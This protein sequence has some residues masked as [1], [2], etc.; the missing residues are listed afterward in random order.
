MKKT[1][2]I[3][4]AIGCI[5]VATTRVNAQAIPRVLAPDPAALLAELQLHEWPPMMHWDLREFPGCDVPWA[6]NPNPV[7]DLDGNGADNTAADRAAARAAFAASFA[8]WEAVAPS[9]IGFVESGTPALGGPGMDGYNTIGFG[10]GA[11]DDVQVVAPGN[12]V[13]AGGVVVGPGPNGVLESQ[14]GGDDIVAGTDIVDGGNLVAESFANTY[15]S[16]V[17]AL[18]FTVLFFDMPTGRIIESDITFDP[19]LAWVVNPAT[20]ACSPP[21]AVA[22]FN[23][24]GTAVHEI[25]HFI[26]IAHPINPNPGAADAADG[27]TPT[28]HPTLCPAFGGNNF[29]Q[30]LENADRDPCNFLYTP[31]LGDAPDPWMGVFNQY[32]TLV[33]LVGQGRVLNELQLDARAEGAEHIFGIK[34]VQGARNWTYEWLARFNGPGVTPECE[35]NI[36]D[37]DPLDDGVTWYPNPP[38]WGRLLTVTAWIKY[39]SDAQGNAHNYPAR[40]LF[41]NAWID[42]NQNC[43]WEEW[44][45]SVGQAPPPPLGPNTI[46]TTTA[47][48]SVFLPPF[49]DPT[50][51]VWLRARVD[52]GE[53]VG[54]INNIDGTLNAERGAAQFGEVEDYPM[55]CRTKYEQQWTQNVLPYPTTGTSL[56]FVGAPDPA[57]QFYSAIVDDNDCPIETAPLPIVSYVPSLDETITEYPVPTTVPPGGRKHSGKCKPN[58]PPGQPP[59][60]LL[61]SHWVTDQ[62]PAQTPAH[63]V[64]PELRIPSVNCEAFSALDNDTGAIDFVRWSVGAVDRGSGGWISMIDEENHVWDDQLTVTVGYRLSPTLLP[65]A[66]LSPCDPA[67]AAL[68]L[69]MVGTG[70][71]TPED[72]LSDIIEEI[73]IPSYLILEVEVSWNTN[74]TLNRQIIEF[75]DPFGEPTPTDDSPLPKS[76]VL[77]SYPNPFNPSTTIRFALPKAETVSLAVYDV[78]G[79]LVRTLLDDARKPAG[80]FEAQWNGTDSNGRQVASGVYFFRLTTSTE[81]L[82]RKAVLLK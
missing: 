82:T 34:P 28:M 79:R 22:A 13:A 71:V 26:G 24:A 52:Y 72:A 59:L 6:M 23:V 60:T 77:E 63:L 80:F 39:A 54:I 27:I 36:V 74:G 33:H 50:R 11:M 3:L 62:V 64:P 41:A 81:T 38:I 70:T 25:G 29:D 75:P 7:P 73:P 20:N 56:V 8:A 68:P 61:R 17:G 67:Y 45:M 10:D 37:R 16:V 53:H 43:V 44:F 31:D 58:N 2:T 46:L 76:L 49:I 1:I 48:A 15:G 57:E 9:I 30:T 65:L 4:L 18:A 35:A 19:A 51:P 42:L 32:P 5:L 12:P 47:T 21:A 40:G 78:T 14:P 55:H 69:T 66:S